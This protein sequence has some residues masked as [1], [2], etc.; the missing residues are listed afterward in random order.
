MP[1]LDPASKEQ[2]PGAPAIGVV[3]LGRLGTAV[4]ERARHLGLPVVL[5]AT[6][7]EWR[8]DRKPDVLVDTSAPDAHERVVTY[9]RDTGTALV[10]CVSNLTDAQWAALEDLASRV[11]VVRATNLA[12]GHHVQQLLVRYVAGLPA[13]C[14]APAGVWERHPVTKAHRPSATAVALAGV[15]R[16]TSGAEVTDISSQRGGLPVSDHE[17]QWTWQGETLTL[18]H[19]VGSLLA[20]ADG[21]LHAVRWAHGRAARTEA[22][23]TVTMTTVYDDLIQRHQAEPEG[24]IP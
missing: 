10:E 12:V 4:A 21:A 9:C 23:R 11:L 24:V 16:E 13:W 2:Y 7:E 19:S 5:R 14:R 3:G 22:P 1:N 18:R 20:A 17:V 15:W 6:R 8:A